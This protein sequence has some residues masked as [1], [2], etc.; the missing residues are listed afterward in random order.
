MQGQDERGCGGLTLTAATCCCV[1]GLRGR[2][3][4]WCPADVR[5]PSV[6]ACRNLRVFQNSVKSFL[7][8]CGAARHTGVCCARPVP[9]SSSDPCPVFRS[10]PLLL[11]RPCGIQIPVLPKPLSCSYPSAPQ[12]PGLLTFGPQT[13]GVLWISILGPPSKTCLDRR[14]QLARPTFTGLWV[15]NRVCSEGL[16]LNPPQISDL[17]RP[18]SPSVFPP[19]PF[20]VCSYLLPPRAQFFSDCQT[21]S[22][23]LLT[24]CV[25][26]H[27]GPPYP[28]PGLQKVLQRKTLDPILLRV[29]SWAMSSSDLLL[30]GCRT[31]FI[32]RDPQY[33]ADW[34]ARGTTCPLPQPPYSG[35]C[36]PFP[37]WLD[38]QRVLA[39]TDF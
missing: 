18:L 29:I 9:A 32:S 13:P 27:L 11:F 5:L 31:H 20:V 2:V 6:G 7:L 28:G 10:L 15:A 4:G 3:E 17:F 33:W 37:A 24:H 21:S 16:S 30:S 25:L 1:G 19:Q 26:S 14:L 8:R 34:S 12:I 38:F 36:Q 35:S 23:N 39:S 22:L